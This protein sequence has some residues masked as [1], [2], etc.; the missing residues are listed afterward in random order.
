MTIEK[1]FSILLI[2]DDI[3][4]A[5]FVK[6]A[7]EREGYQVNTIYNG[8]H[9]L[10]EALENSYSLILL[11][12]NL[13]ETNGIVI[14]KSVRSKSN[15]PIII[16][17]AQNKTQEKVA[18]LDAGANDYITKPVEVDELLARVRVHTRK[19]EYIGTNLKKLNNELVFLDLTV[20]TNT[21]EVIR[22]KTA[23]NLSPKEFDILLYFM[24]N[25]YK[26]LSKQQVFEEVWKCS[27]NSDSDKRLI[28]EHIHK[29]RKKIHFPDY[30]K[31]LHTAY[32]IGYIL[33]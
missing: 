32:G 2:E 29:I 5:F 21:R 23:I 19:T 26:I 30:P 1:E 12:I 18:G 20:N 27:F 15:I 17:T 22:N 31:L 4:L 25:P 7:L 8:A 9:G 28:D 24:K 14:C 16:F 13:P 10:K 6:T 33:K 11:D 3:Q